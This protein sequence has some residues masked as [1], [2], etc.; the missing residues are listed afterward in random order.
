MADNL[1]LAAALG[2]IERAK[3]H[4]DALETEELSA[5]RE[6]SHSITCLNSNWIGNA[7]IASARAAE[8]NLRKLSTMSLSL[9][10]AYIDNSLNLD[11]EADI[12]VELEKTNFWLAYCYFMIGVSKVMDAIAQFSG[13]AARL[14]TDLKTPITDVGKSMTQNNQ[15]DSLGGAQAVNVL[16]IA[17]L[18]KHPELPLLPD[19]QKDLVSLI[20]LVKDATEIW[21]RR[22]RPALWS[23]DLKTLAAS[24]LEIAAK[25]VDAASRSLTLFD[26]TPRLAQGLPPGLSNPVTDRIAN[27]KVIPRNTFDSIKRW[28]SVAKYTAEAIAN[29]LRACISFCDYLESH[30]AA[31]AADTLAH[32]QLSATTDFTQL[33]SSIQMFSNATDADLVNIMHNVNSAGDANHVAKMAVDR[34]RQISLEIVQLENEHK[35]SARLAEFFQSRVKARKEQLRACDGQLRQIEKAIGALPADATTYAGV[36]GVIK[37]DAMLIRVQEM[38]GAIARTINPVPTWN[39]RSFRGPRYGTI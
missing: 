9:G 6:L 21:K 37:R 39:S 5:Y 26:S 33:N 36:A 11:K 17:E 14:I 35:N 10:Q 15:L 30:A 7:Q 4:L 25:V 3:D 23:K 12:S 8:V 1:Q 31:N 27:A 2:E 19:I 29:F 34:L 24:G 22:Q 20:E 28:L 38:R 13:P 32:K 18:R 16:L